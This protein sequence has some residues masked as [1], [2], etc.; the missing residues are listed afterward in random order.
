MFL[1][2]NNTYQ[3]K[4]TKN[5][6]RGVFA[7]KHIPAGTLIGDYIGQV[8][9]DSDAEKLEEKYGQ[10]CYSFEY[11]GADVSLFPVD[12]KAP[13]VHLINHSCGANCSVFDYQG[14]NLYFA[15]R[16]IFPGEELTFDYEF[17]P[18]SDGKVSH[19]FCDSP[20]CRGT[21]YA[22]VE[23]PSLKKKKPVVKKKEKIDYRVYKVGEVLEPLKKY[24]S[25]IKDN[26]KYNVYANLKVPP[27][28]DKQKKLPP[29]KEL[30]EMMRLT[31]RRLK[32]PELNLMVL[33][34]VDDHLVVER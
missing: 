6:G 26:K 16:H 12:I 13:G 21:M 34:L 8:V 28:V 3:I 14:H 4:T 25:E 20:F 7:L 24:P 17:D 11:I 1:I 18:Q 15:I 9:T 27:L 30:R 2:P 33:A 19:C 32:F 5:K 10:G 22:R 31:G 23:K 29:L